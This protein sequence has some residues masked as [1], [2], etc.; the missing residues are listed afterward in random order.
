MNEYST[1]SENKLSQCDPRLQQVFREV[2]QTI[3]HT[4]LEGFRN[5]AAQDADFAAGKTKLQWPNGKHNKTPS[6][7]VDATPYPID[8]GNTQRICYFAGFVLGVAAKLG[9]K[10]RWGGDWLGNQM[11]TKESFVDLNHFELVEP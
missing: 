8:W 7:A 4:I 10:V 1:S 2:L 6:L 9:I 5:E 11:A 3:D